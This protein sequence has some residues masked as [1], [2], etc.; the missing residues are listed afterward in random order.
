[1]SDHLPVSMQFCVGGTVGE[2][3]MR[4]SKI[5]ILY[6]SEIRSISIKSERSPVLFN[7]YDINGRC[8]LRKSVS[9]NQFNVDLSMIKNGFYIVSI[10]T[11]NESLNKKILVK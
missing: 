11:K 4:S 9:R 7:M 8:I 6:D 5:D 1:M 2:K 10:N 3:T